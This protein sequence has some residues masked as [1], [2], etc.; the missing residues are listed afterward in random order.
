MDDP[1]GGGLDSAH[2]DGD[3]WWQPRGKRKGRSCSATVTRRLEEGLAGLRRLLREWVL[4]MAPPSVAGVMLSRCS[5]RE[6]RTTL[7]QP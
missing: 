4:W 2:S 3:G 7:L 6:R 5:A 1:G